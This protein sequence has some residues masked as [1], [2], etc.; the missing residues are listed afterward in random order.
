MIALGADKNIVDHDGCS[1]LGYYFRAIRGINDFD[2]TFACRRAREK[3]KADPMLLRMLTP[4]GGPTAAD[5]EYA[6]ADEKGGG[7]SLPL[8]S[9][10]GPSRDA[11]D[12]SRAVPAPLYLRRPLVRRHRCFQTP[13]GEVACAKVFDSLARAAPR[14]PP[15]FGIHTHSVR[16]AGVEM[17]MNRALFS[18]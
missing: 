14:K 10:Q 17:Q 2:A 1:A 9:A 6:G 5:M 15:A 8:R 11:R 3:C 13:L 12:F 18:L 16:A 7:R 4:E